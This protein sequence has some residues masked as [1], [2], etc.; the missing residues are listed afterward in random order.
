MAVQATK[1][2]VA[3]PAVYAPLDKHF[4]CPKLV[5]IMMAGRPKSDWKGMFDAVQTL[6]TYKRRQAT[7]REPASAAA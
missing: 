7:K 2:P 6:A 1:E 5:K 4:K 3:A